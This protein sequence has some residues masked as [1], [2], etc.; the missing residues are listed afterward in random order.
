MPQSALWARSKLRRKSWVWIWF[1]HKKWLPLHPMMSHK[2]LLAQHQVFIDAVY[3]RMRN[4]VRLPIRNPVFPQSPRQPLYKEKLRILTKLRKICEVAK[5]L[6]FFLFIFRFHL[7]IGWIVA[8]CRLNCCG[9]RLN[10]RVLSAES[11]RFVVWIAAFCWLNRPFLFVQ[12][13]QSKRPNY[14]KGV[15][16]SYS[17]F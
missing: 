17:A 11:P 4:W 9:C 1:F 2:W 5:A 3:S 6:G 16:T 7:F 14:S 15:T 12:T 8:V 13:V 10:R